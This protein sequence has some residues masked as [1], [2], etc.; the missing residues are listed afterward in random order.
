M[1]EPSC[2]GDDATLPFWFTLPGRFTPGVDGGRLNDR[3]AI[4]VKCS[5]VCSVRPK[6]EGRDVYL[7]RSDPPLFSLAGVLGVV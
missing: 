1:V 2:E 4:C 7:H 3:A 6:I 5:A